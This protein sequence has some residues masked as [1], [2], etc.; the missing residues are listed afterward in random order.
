MSGQSKSSV[1]PS[2]YDG[3]QDW[4]RA[5]EI[6]ARSFYKE[7]RANGLNGR[8]IVELSNELLRLVSSDF[9]KGETRW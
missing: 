6:L 8:Q 5:R 7:L 4:P 1:N 2:P 9:Q 3:S